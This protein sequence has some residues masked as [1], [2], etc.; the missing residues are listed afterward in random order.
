[1]NMK[2]TLLAGCLAV[3][4][5]APA[6]AE[7]I[8]THELTLEGTAFKPAELHVKAGEPFVIKFTNAN[9][10]PA[11]LESIDLKVEK[12]APP[13]ATI[14]VRVLPP[15]AGTYEFV[16]EFQEDVAKGTIIAE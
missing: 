12:I 1:M 3:S 7:D 11:E 13:N 14:M 2:L 6:R 16:D 9:S 4:A 8:A 5:I 15:D 10:A